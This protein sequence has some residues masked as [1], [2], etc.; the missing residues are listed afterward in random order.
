LQLYEKTLYCYPPLNSHVSWHLL[1]QCN[2]SSS[3]I[4]NSSAL[5]ATLSLNLPFDKALSSSSSS[6][7]LNNSSIS[8]FLFFF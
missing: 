4:Y 2:S 5:K 6:I 3:R 7:L 8:F 1:N